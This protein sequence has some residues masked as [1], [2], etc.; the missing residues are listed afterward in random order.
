MDGCNAFMVYLRIAVPNTKPVFVTVALLSVIFYWK[1][2]V[3]SGMFLSSID[4]QP[5]MLLI[6][7]FKSILWQ[8]G[9]T[10]DV[11]RYTVEISAA[12]RLVISPLILVFLI[13]QKFFIECMDRS[14][15]KG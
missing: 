6:D 10:Q 12:R 15:I 9:G 3:I 5:I 1:D 14:G 13:C 2:T 8:L 4:Q 7:S 11:G